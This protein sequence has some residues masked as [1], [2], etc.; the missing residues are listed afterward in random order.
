MTSSQYDGL[1]I[2]MLIALT[3]AP[4]LIPLAAL[5]WLLRHLTQGR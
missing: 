5:V 3:L 2:A 4:F 1:T